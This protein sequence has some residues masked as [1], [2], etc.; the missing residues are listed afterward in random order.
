MVF[1]SDNDEAVLA[2]LSKYLVVSRGHDG[3]RNMDLAASTSVPGRFVLIQKWDTIEAQQAHF[4]SG[5]MVEMAQ[6]VTPMLRAA[7]SI[8]LLE[9]ISVHDLY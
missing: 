3:C 7:P 2:V 6:A 8:D 4:D 1:E 9:P 5:E